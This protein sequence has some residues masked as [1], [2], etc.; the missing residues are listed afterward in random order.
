[1]KTIL[2]TITIL[3][4]VS[5][6]AQN[7]KHKKWAET[8]KASQVS[9]NSNV[10]GIAVTNDVNV[11]SAITTDAGSN[12]VSVTEILIAGN[13]QRLAVEKAFA[14]RAVVKTSVQ[15]LKASFPELDTAFGDLAD[16]DKLDTFQR[17]LKSRIDAA[18]TFSAV[19]KIADKLPADSIAKARDTVN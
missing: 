10:A 12:G 8:R 13:A 9:T 18:Q 7:A 3:V 1:M 14:Y 2:I 19:Q 6:F 5:G 4:A 11:N 15:D 16:G 17:L